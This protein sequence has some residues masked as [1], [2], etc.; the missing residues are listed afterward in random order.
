MLAENSEKE[1]QTSQDVTAAVLSFQGECVTRERERER[2]RDVR[3]FVAWLVVT[4]AAL[5]HFVRH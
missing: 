2:E 3:W 1:Q 5:E 4:A